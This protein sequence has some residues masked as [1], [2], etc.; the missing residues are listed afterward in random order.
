MTGSDIGGKPDIKNKRSVAAMQCAE[1]RNAES[2]RDG[3][4]SGLATVTVDFIRHL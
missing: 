2:R 4:L 3:R 1:A